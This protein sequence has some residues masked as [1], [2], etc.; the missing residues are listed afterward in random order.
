[1]SRLSPH[2]ELFRTILLGELPA[3]A[4]AA[5]GRRA[6]PPRKAERKGSVT[7]N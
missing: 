1:V 7:K 6:R 3:A 4:T 2:A 5:S